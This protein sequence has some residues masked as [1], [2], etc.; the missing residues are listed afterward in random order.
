MRMNLV[1]SLDPEKNCIM[2]SKSDITEII[3]GIETD[4]IIKEL[5]KSFLNK[6]QIKFGK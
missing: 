2:D 5:F 1:S 4:N 3:M 6:Y